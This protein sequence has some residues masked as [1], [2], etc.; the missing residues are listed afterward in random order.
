MSKVVSF[1][2]TFILLTFMLSFTAARLG[3]TDQVLQN[4][5]RVN[6]DTSKAEIRDEINC[7]MLEK[8]ECLFRRSLAAHLDYIYTQEQPPETP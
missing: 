1:C 2:I 4:Q 3:H 6:M 7:E 8:D 5:H